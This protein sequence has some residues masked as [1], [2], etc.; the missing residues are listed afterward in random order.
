[1]AL[2]MTEHA[3]NGA[4]LPGLHKQKSTDATVLSLGRA[5]ERQDFQSIAQ[6]YGF[7]V[8]RVRKAGK[9]QG[10]AL[11]CIQPR[12]RCMVWRRQAGHHKPHRALHIMKARRNP[13][14][15][16]EGGRRFANN[17]GAIRAGRA[18]G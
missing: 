5:P 3:S 13:R 8:E 18:F 7:G 15:V 17:Q 9:G 16:L 4:P 1:M 12:K 6:A 2:V 11:C 14:T 10:G